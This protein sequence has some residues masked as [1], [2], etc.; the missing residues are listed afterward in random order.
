M[1]FYRVDIINT[2]REVSYKRSLIMQYISALQL[3]IINYRIF[4]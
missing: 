1:K 4:E 2:S 3:A